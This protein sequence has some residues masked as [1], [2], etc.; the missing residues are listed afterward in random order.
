MLH[1]DANN[2]VFLQF[3]LT[4]ALPNNIVASDVD[5][6][7]LKI[8]LTELEKPGHLTIKRVEQA[9]K[10]ASLPIKGVQPI[11]DNLDKKDVY[12]SKRL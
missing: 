1:I 11:L 7:T 4:Q 9:W 6:A 10:E 3:S 12:H 8:F 5:K 2:T